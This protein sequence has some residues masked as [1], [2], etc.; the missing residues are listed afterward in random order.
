MRVEQFL[1]SSA[2]RY[3]D[4]A[5]LV[6]GGTRL[7]FAD[8]DAASDRLSKS[9]HR[10]GVA[11]GDRIVVFLDNSWEAIV[12]IFAALKTGAVFIPINPLTKADKLAYVLNNCRAKALI[13]HDRQ[14]PISGEAVAKAPSIAFTVIVGAAGTDMV[15]AGI[16][17]DEM[18]VDGSVELETVD[19]GIDLDLAMLIYTSGSTGHPKGVMMTHSNIDFST[20]SIMTYLENTS[21]DI[22][23]NALPISFDYGLYQVF[24]ATRL[25]STLVLEK[26]FAFPQVILQKLATEKVTGFPIVPTMA[27]LLLQMDALKIG[28]FPYLR[29][30]TNTAAALPPAHI[31]RLQMLFPT[32]KIFS[33]YGLTECKRTT[34]LP[35]EQL[36]HRP[37]SVGIAIPGTEAYVV[38][39]NGKRASP[40][41]VGEL[42]TRG[43]HVMKGYWENPEATDRVL[44]IGPYPWEKVLYT[45]DLF[46]ADNEGFLYFVARKDDILKIRGEKVAPKEIENVLYSIP[47]VREAVVVGVPDPILG[48]AIKAVLAIDPGTALTTKDVMH[49]CAANLEAYMVPKY[50]EFSDQLPKTESG[51]VSRRLV[52]EQAAKI[53]E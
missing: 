33:M 39:D 11:H 27:A 51:K 43:S 15:R 37:G 3:P 42:V 9:L 13:T 19:A 49:H 52:T 20:K 1:R 16:S 38:D 45:G 28:E 22:I 41:V 32:T 4:K 24:M 46:Y 18:L 6:A 47:G 14:L 23:I 53:S 12:S 34:W 30:I 26:S 5:A 50:V 25:G 7:T 10:H 17:F 44:K 29:Y 36:R 8:L 21:D 40:G 31:E 2:S 48:T 35:P